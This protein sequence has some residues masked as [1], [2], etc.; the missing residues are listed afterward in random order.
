MIRSFI[1]SLLSGPVAV[2]LRRYVVVGTTTA[3]VQ[4]LLLWLFVDAGGA[5]Y[6]LGATVAIEITIVMTYV[7]NNA[8]TFA[9][10]QN[11]GWADYLTGLV[12]TNVVRGTA[13]PI[14]LAVLYA[15]VDFGSV[16]YLLANAVGI[17]VSGV[18][19]YV[20]DAKWTWGRT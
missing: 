9:S 5:N 14:Q 19:R 16:Q 6:L 18:Y 2:Q 1:R 20:F 4:M 11:T 12:K 10:M 15:L 3:G 17:V 7:L 13:I 8:W